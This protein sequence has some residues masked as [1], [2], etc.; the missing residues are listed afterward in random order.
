MGVVA[1]EA[2]VRVLV[3]CARDKAWDCCCTFLAGFKGRVAESF[4]VGRCE[5]GDALDGWEEDTANVCAVA[6]GLDVSIAILRIEYVHR[7]RDVR[8]VEAKGSS[9]LVRG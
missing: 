6:G 2:E 9:D 8:S 4:G 5:C 7:R 3:Y 1:E